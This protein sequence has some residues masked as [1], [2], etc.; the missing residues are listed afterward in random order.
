MLC[1][2]IVKP[3][4]TIPG[5]PDIVAE[6]RFCSTLGDATG[7]VPTRR[8]DMTTEASR[9]LAEAE[10]CV[11]A[12][13]KG[14]STLATGTPLNTSFSFLY[15]TPRWAPSCSVSD[16][17]VVPYL[18]LR[19]IIRAFRRV[20]VRQGSHIFHLYSLTGGIMLWQL[21]IVHLRGPP[22]HDQ[23]ARLHI[24]TS[25][26]RKAGHPPDVVAV[27]ASD[28]PSSSSRS[29]LVHFGTLARR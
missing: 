18:R 16:M 5:K 14:S 20:R 13:C 6:G 17:P 24:Q 15:L 26:T 3:S 25:T 9:G 10:P 2:Y 11:A 8:V 12:E 29:C 23:S 28:L 7:V 4:P 22:A 27:S 1:G 21:R 19:A